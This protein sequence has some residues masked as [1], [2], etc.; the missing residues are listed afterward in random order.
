MNTLLTP[1]IKPI[2][3]QSRKRSST[4][5]T[6]TDLWEDLSSLDVAFDS[7][8]RDDT[9]EKWNKKI[10]MGNKGSLGNKNLKIVNQV[11][12]NTFKNRI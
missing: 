1:H 5:E 3:K 11:K 4:V 8:Y 9:I 10:N 2:N 6:L 7:Y 12:T